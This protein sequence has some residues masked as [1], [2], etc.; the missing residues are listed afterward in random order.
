SLSTDGRAERCY[1]SVLLELLLNCV[2]SPYWVTMKQV[3]RHSHEKKNHGPQE[4]TRE[5]DEAAYL[6]K[7][8]IVQVLAYK[9]LT[10]GQL[11]M[12]L[13][14]PLRSC[15][16]VIS[17]ELEQLA[18][19]AGTSNGSVPRE[20]ARSEDVL[21]EDSSVEEHT[22]RTVY[23]LKSA[24]WPYYDA[25]C[26]AFGN[27]R[28]REAA[29]EHALSKPEVGMVGPTDEIECLPSMLHL[30]TEGITESLTLTDPDSTSPPLDI[31][32]LIFV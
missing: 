4:G 24:S 7:R 26:L 10:F 31:Y 3:F 14:G 1:T 23:S 29:M 6:A 8:A 16:A 19:R 9:N 25:Y 12:Y 21:V 5:Y 13:P 30:F 17:S 32:E 15:E 18:Q 11:A 27:S 2:A 20:R 22:G 28:Q